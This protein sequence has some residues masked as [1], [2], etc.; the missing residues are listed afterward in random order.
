MNTLDLHDLFKFTN[1]FSQ[2]LNYD[3]IEEKTIFSS[4]YC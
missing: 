2:L 4:N 1:Q 3:Q